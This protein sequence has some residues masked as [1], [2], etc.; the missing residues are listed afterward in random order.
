MKLRILS[1]AAAALLCIAGAAGAKEPTHARNDAA[2]RADPPPT[3]QTPPAA[4][5]L[6]RENVDEEELHR[7]EY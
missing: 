5:P 1:I 4:T 3:H 7:Y 2:R 6:H